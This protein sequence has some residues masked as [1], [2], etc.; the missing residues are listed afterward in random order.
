MQS[1]P[2]Q[3]K[4]EMLVA[5]AQLLHNNCLYNAVAHA[6]YYSCYQIL[7]YIWL[8]S[9]KRTQIELDSNTS[10][11]RIG[12]HEYLLNEVVK[13]ISNSQYKNSKKDARDL[14]NDIPQLKKLRIDADYS[15]TTFDYSKSRESIDLS[16]ELLSILKKY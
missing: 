4:S 2:L 6:A 16:S 13:Y 9:M 10:Q 3:N 15:D 8:Y 7:K 5:A 11:S 1:T 12:S 14:R